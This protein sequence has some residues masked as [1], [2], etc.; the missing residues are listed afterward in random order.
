MRS[1]SDK[2]LIVQCAINGEVA[3]FLLDTGASVGL[4]NYRERKRYQIKVGR[5]FPTKLVGAGGDLDAYYCNTF[6]WFQNR[7]IAQFLLAD[8]N[9]VVESIKQETGIEI[10]GIICLQQMKDVG[11]DI[12]ANSN[13]I[14]IED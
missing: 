7:Q 8:I 2:R 3:R 9:N 5:R 11:I 4:I 1:L 10:Q 14:S 12:D 6:V 13:D